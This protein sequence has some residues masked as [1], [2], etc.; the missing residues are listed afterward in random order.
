VRILITSI[1]DLRK[2]SHNRLHQFIKH[3][4]RNHSITS[5]SIN[6]WWKTSQTDVSRYQ[7][8]VEDILEGVDIKYFTARKLSP[9]LQEIFSFVTLNRILKGIDYTRFDVH[10]NY[11]TLISGYYVAKKLKSAGINTVYDIADDL[12]GMIRNSPQI[13][14]VL[15]PLG[16]MV[17]T[18]M[19]NKNIKIS[20]TVTCINGS[21]RDSYHVPQG[22]FE[23][24]SN[25]VDTELFKSYPSQQ[26]RQEL[27]LETDFV[28]GYVGVLREWV[29]LEPVIAA[30]SQLVGDHS[31]IK[32]L[33]VGEEGGLRQSQGLAQRYGISD[34]LVLTGTVPYVKVPE[35]ISCMD[36]CLIPFKPNEMSRNA[37]PLKLFE[38]MACEKPVICSKLKGVVQIAGDKVLYASNQEEYKKELAALYNNKELRE[39][40]GV[41]GRKFVEKYYRWAS[42]TSK[43]EEVLKSASG[44]QS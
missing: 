1:I 28:V 18:T 7:L 29:D 34:R 37:V 22:K 12:P 42:M 21:L 36:V 13:P 16:R 20:K 17:G 38:Y 5:L 26:L 4:S 8:G 27:G 9:Y 44:G 43:L 14:P 41:N 32:L 3:L 11:S 6:D 35:Y 40:L 33:I 31:N 10:L 39:K 19:V 30:L 2:S 23:L 25:G 15:R 24:I